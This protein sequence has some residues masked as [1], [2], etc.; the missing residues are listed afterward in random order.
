MSLRQIFFVG[1][2]TKVQTQGDSKSF[3]AAKQALGALRQDT[4]ADKLQVK[5]NKNAQRSKLTMSA[6]R[7]VLNLNG[8]VELNCITHISL[9]INNQN[10]N[11]KQF[12]RHWM[13]KGN[14]RIGGNP[15][16]KGENMHAQSF[17]RD[18]G[19]KLDQQPSDVITT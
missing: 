3:L 5:N 2:A 18:R 4:D 17:R 9:K 7:K 10:K 6:K 19:I 8:I 1:L 11:K 15:E 12:L 14:W 13:V 16:R